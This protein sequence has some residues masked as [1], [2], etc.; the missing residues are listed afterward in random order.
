[1][2]ASS[3]C[4][5][6]AAPGGVPATGTVLRHADQAMYHAKRDGG[7][8]HLFDP[9]EPPPFDD[10]PPSS[11]STQGPAVAT[12][13]QIGSPPCSPTRSRPS[14]NRSNANGAMS[15]DVAAPSRISSLIP[16][17][18]AGAVLNPVPLCPQS[19]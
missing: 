16:R 5:V 10:Q 2:G 3:A 13:L 8:V 14:A 9:D 17:P 18:T 4:C 19:R 7:G 12:Y 11:R 6:I 1:M 15:T